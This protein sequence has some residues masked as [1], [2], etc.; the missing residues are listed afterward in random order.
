MGDKKRE[1]RSGRKKM[2]Y[3]RIGRDKKWERL[4]VGEIRS[5]GVKKWER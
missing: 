1:I 5:G 2:G 3:I 4:E